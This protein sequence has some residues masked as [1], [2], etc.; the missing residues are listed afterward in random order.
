MK[1][2]GFVLKVRKDRIDE[3]K[4]FHRNVWPEMQ[5]A[6]SRNGWDNYSLFMREDGLMFGYFEAPVDFQTALD[7]MAKEKINGQWQSLM[8]EFFEI[9]EGSAPD[10]MMVQL[11]EVFHLDTID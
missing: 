11:E 2:V 7:S 9:P 5:E 6:L 1:H 4:E 3:Y 10:Q 8:S